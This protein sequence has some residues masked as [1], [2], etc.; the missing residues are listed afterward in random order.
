MNLGATWQT[1]KVKSVLGP[2]SQFGPEFFPSAPNAQYCVNQNDGSFF[3]DYPQDTITDAKLPNAPQ[4]SF[5]YLFRYN[6]DMLGGNLAAQLDGA[7]YGRQ[8]LEVT[9]GPSSIQPAYNVS[10][11]SLTWTGASDRFSLQVFGRN[12]FDEEYR[13]YTLNLGILGTTSVYA[14]PATYGVTATVRW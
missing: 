5:N 2:G 11:A 1:N 7:W 6:V 10:N 3:C 4:F 8:F 9:N 13:A 14:K 12:I